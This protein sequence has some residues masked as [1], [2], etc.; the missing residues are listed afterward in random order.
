MTGRRVV[1]MTIV[2][3]APRAKLRTT[4]RAFSPARTATAGVVLIMKFVVLYKSLARD[5]LAISVRE[6]RGFAPIGHGISHA[7]IRDHFYS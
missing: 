1:S 7:S 3:T 2:G 5:E 6:N 4:P